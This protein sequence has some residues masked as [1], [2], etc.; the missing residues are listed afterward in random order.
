MWDKNGVRIIGIDPGYSTGIVMIEYPDRILT[1]NTIEGK[2]PIRYIVDL[3]LSF[4]NALIVVEQAPNDGDNT[5]AIRV[6]RI[7]NSIEANNRRV[8]MIFPGKWKPFS[9]AQK[10]DYPTASSQHE[11]DAYCI[12]KYFATFKVK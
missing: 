4:P 1:H 10:W 7:V 11:K 8:H 6:S 5:Q 9:K 12:A 3:V 2:S